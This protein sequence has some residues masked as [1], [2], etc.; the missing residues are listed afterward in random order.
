MGIQNKHGGTM[1]NMSN[2]KLSFLCGEI[3][4]RGN[5]NDDSDR[6]SWNGN[7]GRGNEKQQERESS[8]FLSPP[9]R[10]NEGDGERCTEPRGVAL[11]PA[12]FAYLCRASFACHLHHHLA[13][14]CSFCIPRS[15]ASFFSSLSLEMHRCVRSLH[16][17]YDYR[18]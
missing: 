3:F 10:G 8:S 4:A 15:T 12:R 6:I 5:N 13:L 7:P 1:G 9:N 14:T 2:R 11:Q 16:N 17:Y 18:E